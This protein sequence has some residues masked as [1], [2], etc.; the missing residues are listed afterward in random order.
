MLLV[1]YLSPLSAQETERDSI[2]PINL[3][4]VIVIGKLGLN[5]RKQEKP[6]S[7]IDDYLEKSNKISMIK[8]GNYAWEPAMNNMLSDRLSVTIDGMQIFGACTDKMDP[9]TSYVDISNLSE[10]HVNS[11]QSGSVNG[12]TIGGGI[13]MKL[14]KSNFEK[15]DLNFGLDLG[16]ESNTNAKI[17]SS[18][19]N[20][21]DKKFT[22]NSD[23]IYRKSENYFA[24]GGDE[25]MFSQYEKFNISTVAGVK[26]GK[27]SAIVGSFIFDRAND[28]GYP[29]LTMDVSLAKALIASVSFEQKNIGSTINK[30]ETKLYYN[31][32]THVMDDTKRP[33]VPIH[34]DMP[35]Q[36]DTYG[37]YS[38]INAAK[39]KHNLQF[40][41]NGYYNKSLAEMTMYPE[42]PDENLMFMLTWP[43]VRTFYSGI[44]GED[45]IILN[46]NR[47]LKISARAGFQNA[48]IANDFGLNSL[49]I[50]Y[51]EL[52]DNT[53]RFLMNF[54]SEYNIKFKD[55]NVS[56]G[57][58]Y[59]ERAPSVTEAYGF[60]LY[61]SFDNYDY[62]G[63]PYLKNEKST[64]LNLGVDYQINQFEIGTDLSFFYIT[65][66]IIGKIA[67][68][69]DKMTIGADGVR[70]YEGL[71]YATIF[72]SN[73]TM[74]YS[75]SQAIKMDASLGYN[76]GRDNNGDNL[77][78]ISP[79]TYKT[80]L[81]YKNKAFNARV[82]MKGAD[83]QYNFSSYY[84]EDSTSAYTIF[85]TNASY[86]FYFGGQILYVKAGVQNIFDRYYSTYTDWKNIPRMGRNVFLNVSYVL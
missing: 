17:I 9:I 31:T 52:K 23:A 50:F 77:P 76:L 37:F 81:N 79:I 19:F 63:N 56:I 5:N 38:K 10:V 33:Y 39:L 21:S 71:D 41:F 83:K 6:L 8:R 3:E 48:L 78:L 14:Q 46:D 2:L 36:S 15:E 60:Y 75:F 51:P 4:E 70:I 26:V 86:N 74:A 55:L 16:S 73:L 43:D 32:V 24:G 13:D 57:A 80:S 25:V 66:Y 22:L 42:N 11:G 62:V 45:N 53:S 65:N 7:S 84:G 40:N 27:N 58:G 64:E 82:S 28:V 20:Y 59:G 69:I 44:Y 68:N 67:P 35:G 72:N 34:M 47:K 54:S 1:C 85:N 29:A 61:N 30:W 18:E 49:R 12:A